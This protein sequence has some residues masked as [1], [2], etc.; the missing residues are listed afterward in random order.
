MLTI[1]LM[2]RSTRSQAHAGR[3][4]GA[5]PARRRLA[6]GTARAVLIAALVQPAPPAPPEDPMARRVAAWTVCH[7]EQGRAATDTCYPRITGKPD[8]YLYSQLVNFR[9]GRRQY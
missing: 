2:N 9:D 4:G 3:A 6:S 5:R 1:E 8:G 7:G